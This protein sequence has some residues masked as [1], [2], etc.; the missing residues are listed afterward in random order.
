MC[1][2]T[3]HVL[4]SIRYSDVSTLPRSKVE[5]YGRDDMQLGHV[6]IRRPTYYQLSRLRCLLLRVP[7]EYRI[8]IS[9]RGRGTQK[10]SHRNSI[11]D[12]DPLAMSYRG[13]TTKIHRCL[14]IG[15]RG[16]KRVKGTQRFHS[17][18][19][20]NGGGISVFCGLWWNQK[21]GTSAALTIPDAELPSVACP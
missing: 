2:P 20:S 3:I 11:E 13:E 18:N 15:V 1:T 19:R 4:S 7:Y 21:E 9:R 8:P 6:S 12:H 5:W 16:K 14:R 17:T 10:L